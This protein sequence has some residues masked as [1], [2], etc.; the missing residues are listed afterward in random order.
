MD[1]QDVLEL[2]KEQ[3]AHEL[4]R[5][6]TI[7]SHIQV[8]FAAI[9]TVLTI[10]L[11]IVKN[12]DL[13]VPIELLIFLSLMGIFGISLLVKSVYLVLDAYWENEFRFFP[14]A[15]Q[16]EE[17]RKDIEE[18]GHLK[19]NPDAFTDYLIEEF[20]ACAGQIAQMNDIRQSKLSLMNRPFKF[21]LI[22]LSLVGL[23]FI[24]CDLDAASSRKE[25]SVSIIS[26]IQCDTTTIPNKVEQ[27]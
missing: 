11:Y 5:K 14:F 9:A 23:I 25:T 1:K 13:S 21:S 19:V 16:V 3:Y 2:Y 4:A 8:R 20:S 18:K 26:P 17:T 22:P 10:L 7:S 24:F 6:D 15:D 12:T 27:E